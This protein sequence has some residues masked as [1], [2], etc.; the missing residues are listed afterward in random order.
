M[1]RSLLCLLVLAGCA[2]APKPIVPINPR[3]QEL[4]IFFEDGNEVVVRECPNYYNITKR[5]ECVGIENRVNKDEFYKEV[6]KL[7][8]LDEHDYYK[9][10]S[11]EEFEA[12]KQDWKL[13]E[14]FDEE[15]EREFKARFGQIKT[16]ITMFQPEFDSNTDLR[17]L[18]QTLAHAEKDLRTGKQ[19]STAINGINLYNRSLLKKVTVSN[20]FFPHGF[21]RSMYQFFLPVLK[22]F[23]P[24]LTSTCGLEG[25]IEDRKKSCWRLRY[26]IDGTP[27]NLVSRFPDGT[28][29][30]LAPDQTQVPQPIMHKHPTEKDNWVIRNCHNI[31]EIGAIEECNGSIITMVSSDE[32]RNAW[33]S[34]VGL[35]PWNFIVPYRA[36]EK[37]A[38]WISD[39]LEADRR[40]SREKYNQIKIE[41]LRK[42]INE[43]Q[44]FR[45][46]KSNANEM[47]VALRFSLSDLNGGRERS[48]SVSK[49]NDFLSKTI[50]LTL[51]DY[52]IYPYSFNP[53]QNKFIADLLFDLTPYARPA[54]GLS[55]D[56]EFRIK[57][58]SRSQLVDAHQWDL[59]TRTDAGT[60]V[61]RD[62]VTKFL[63]GTES[64]RK[65]GHMQAIEYCMDKRSL[66]E[67]GNLGD[68]HWELPSLDDY[69][70]ADVHGIGTLFLDLNQMWNWTS[71]FKQ[72]DKAVSV[73][74]Y[75]KD[76]R[77]NS[78]YEGLTSLNVRCVSKP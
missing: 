70:R 74:F 23:D 31:L 42:Y 29:V 1:M 63:W 56:I 20:T 76:S 44:E 13:K 11:Q 48:R 25:S 27:W 28:T 52:Q 75:Q 72:N 64:T 36:N 6:S 35:T 5:S 67:R 9:V 69:R 62:P 38:Y 33:Y 22:E 60:E 14:K 54:C 7:V 21:S 58:C 57:S 73:R 77:P 18:E 53:V 43:F 40:E 65:M 55:G 32:I 19:N 24:A 71:T 47:E 61:W 30:W 68:R 8:T 66:L 34:K 16:F 45:G 2:S 10:Y 15:R 37:K 78:T 49:V 50:L 41:R 39:K 59:V 3:L 17:L 4:L 46:L 26:A 12:L 51:K